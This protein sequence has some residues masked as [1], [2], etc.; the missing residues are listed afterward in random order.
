MFSKLA[1]LFTKIY[2][3]VY[4][5]SSAFLTVVAPTE[6]TSKTAISSAFTRQRQE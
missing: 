4:D 1:G 2:Q 6:N 3:M 5:G